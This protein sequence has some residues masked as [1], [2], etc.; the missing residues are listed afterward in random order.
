MKEKDLRPCDLCEKA[1]AHDGV[2]LFYR[3]RIEIMGLDLSA[4]RR[5]VGLGMLIGNA[6][7]ARVMG[8]DEDMAKPVVPAEDVIICRECAMTYPIVM[9]HGI[10]ADRKERGQPA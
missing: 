5:Q 8:P 1:L 6:A 10:A 4:I 2:P 7:I 9:A 3:V